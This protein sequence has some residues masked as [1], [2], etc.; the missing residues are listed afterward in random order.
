M[1]QAKYV[2]NFPKGAEENRGAYSGEKRQEDDEVYEEEDDG[3][4]SKEEPF[5]QQYLKGRADLIATEQKQRSG[6]FPQSE[7]FS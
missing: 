2:A 5:I 6:Q 3:V 4:P 7:S 1:S